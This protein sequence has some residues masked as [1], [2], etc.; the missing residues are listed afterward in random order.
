MSGII[1]TADRVLQDMTNGKK[2]KKT[3]NYTLKNCQYNVK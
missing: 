2:A 3:K 1:S